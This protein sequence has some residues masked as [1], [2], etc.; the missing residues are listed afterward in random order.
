MRISDWSSDVCSS[1]L[2]DATDAEFASE[3]RTDLLLGDARVELLHLR[4]RLVALGTP[5]LQEFAR[6][7][8]SGRKLLRTGELHASEISAGLC[9]SA[10]R[11]LRRVIKLYQQRSRPDTAARLKLYADHSSGNLRRK[12]HLTHGAH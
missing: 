2:I 8:A 3:G 4:N 12:H 11:A 6:L 10:V 5:L 9:R 7:R 1:D